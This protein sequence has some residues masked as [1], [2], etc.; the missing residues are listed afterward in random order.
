MSGTK[1]QPPVVNIPL[2]RRLPLIWVVPI[3]AIAIGAYLFL[4]SL[5]QRGDEITITFDAANGLKAGTKVEH[6]AVVLGT[7]TDIGLTDDLTRVLVHVR[8]TS[9]ADPYLTDQTRFWVVRPHL[10]GGSVAGLNTL[11]SGDTIE[12]DPGNGKGKK[13]SAFTGLESPPAN[14]FGVSGTTYV[15]QA[16]SIAS[17]TSGTPVIY[18]DVQVGEVLDNH[19]SEGKATVTADIF[20]QAPYDK[21]VRT[22]TVFWQAA[23]LTT[24]VTG[25]GLH[26]QVNSLQAAVSGG[27][28]FNVPPGAPEYPLA[29][30]GT[31][32]PLFAY[33]DEAIRAS[34]SQRIPY[35]MYFAESAAG[36]N[37]GAPVNID[38]N[39]VGEVTGMRLETV[40]PAATPRVR[41]A[42]NLLPQ[43]FSV[44]G[45]AL[46]SDP[47]AATRELI[48]RGLRAKLETTGYVIGSQAVSLSFEPKPAPATLQ[49]EGEVMVLPTEAGSGS[50]TL[51]ASLPGMLAKV[52][53]IP[54][55]ATAATADKTLTTLTATLGGPGGKQAIARLAATMTGLQGTIKRTE[56]SIGPMLQALP[57]QADSLLQTLRQE[58]ATLASADANYGTGS[59]MPA[60]LARKMAMYFDLARYVRLTADYLDRHPEAVIHGNLSKGSEQ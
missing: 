14:R 33:E 30:Q 32:Y 53:D 9:D 45:T 35:V 51:L 34:Y 47:V 49:F 18:R 56:A 54:F 3:T 17:L 6:K 59:N 60:E 55:Q 16:P 46:P 7:V 8:M 20:V 29:S 27:V 19:I 37:V 41:V 15:L 1:R 44:L 57:A 5:V 31:T 24:G 58:N 38:D 21:E 40:L 50:S 4:S 10:A 43:R 2:W 12:L 39:R 52:T 25:T 11:L 13:Q 22:G 48:A 36:L 28:A 42:I 23:G 26:I